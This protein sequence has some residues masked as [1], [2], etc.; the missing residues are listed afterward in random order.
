MGK[1]ICISSQKGGVGKTIT[2]V[3]L[4]TALAL[5]E[6]RTLLIDMDFQGHATSA[7]SAKHAEKG[8]YDILIQKIPVQEAIKGSE[9]EYLKLIP[10]DIRL[11]GV[12]HDLRS[13]N[14]REHILYNLLNGV[15]KEYDFII[16][17]SPPSFSFL[18]VNSIIAA[19]SI[20]IPMQC[21]CFALESLG[22]FF[23][24]F[25]GL[26]NKYK[27]RAGL[28]GIFLNMFDPYEPLSIRIA[29]EVRKS[30]NRMVYRSVIPRCRSLKES[31]CRGKS[32]LLTDISSKGAKGFISL[33][34]EII[35][36]RH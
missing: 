23:T 19:D 25:N 3:N 36:S 15:K 13:S 9:I 30:F 26:R 34:R 4:S 5:A 8:V 18:S 2:A 22:Q 27:A 21:E 20:I 16:I 17:D 35:G 7:V 33:A 24:V 29:G 6:K 12:E 10:A 11:L 31:A 1:I 32:I 28:R 14:N